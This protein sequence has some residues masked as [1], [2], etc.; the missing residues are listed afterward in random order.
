MIFSH[1]ES[2][3][4]FLRYEPFAVIN[5]DDY[6]GKEAFVKLHDFLVDYTP[7]KANQFCMAGFILKNT[8][9]E[10]GAV[11]RGI[12][13]TNEEGYLTAVH[14]TSNIVKTPEG[15]AVDND[16]QLTSINAESYAS[17]N[18]WGLT[19]EF[20]QTLED[21]FKEFFAN[22]GNKD[23]DV[24]SHCPFAYVLF[25]EFYDFFEVCD[26]ASSA[27]LPHSGKSWLGCEA[28]AVMKF[29]FIPFVYCWRA[30]TD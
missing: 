14:E 17:M 10:N 18:M 27:Y 23:I 29:V 28:G 7:E 13:E 2:S 8:L 5:A 6:Y 15:A 16:G 25:I 1:L 20:M 11:T 26:I 24:K 21:G 12:C 19:P 22:M 30:G 9:S 3:L 4:K